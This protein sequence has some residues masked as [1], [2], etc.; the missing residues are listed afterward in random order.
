MAVA[1]VDKVEQVLR[2]ATSVIPS[3]RIFM[4]VPNYGY[5]WTLPYVPG[6]SVARALSNVEAI[7]QAIQVGAHIQ[8]DETAQ[9][10]FYN[11]WRNNAEHEVWFEDARSIRA[12]LLLA[13]EYRLRGIS[14]WNIMQYFPQLWMVLNAL[15]EIEKLD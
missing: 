9:T 13:N 1:P 2:F 4:G 5:D 10:P 12:K 15:F 6:E 3:G 14:V 8:Y 7:D 11:Y